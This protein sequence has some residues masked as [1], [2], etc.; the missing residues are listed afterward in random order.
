[1]STFTVTGESGR[2]LLETDDW[3]A[4]QVVASDSL[5]RNSLP[6]IRGTH[7]SHKWE[8]QRCTQCGGWDNGS[9]GSQAPCDYD[10]SHAS[11]HSA[12]EREM[13]ARGQVWPARSATVNLPVGGREPLT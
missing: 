13:A 6:H 7:P 4:A 12:L 1:M 5:R 8:D 9:Y 2:V 3:V 11:L 10:W